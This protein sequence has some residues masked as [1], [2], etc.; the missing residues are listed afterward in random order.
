[1]KTGFF[2]LNIHNKKSMTKLFTTSIVLFFGLSLHAQMA[3]EQ[4]RDH[5][6]NRGTIAV[7]EGNNRVY[8]ANQYMVYSYS[9]QDNSLETI[10]KVDKLSDVGISAMAFDA[11]SSTLVVGYENG[12]IDLIRNG[13][14][15]NINSIVN[16]DMFGVKTIND[17]T[18]ESGRCYFSCGFG[19]VYF[20][21]INQEVI[22]TYIIGPGGVNLQVYAVDKF[23]GKIYAATDIGLMAA[24]ADN[25]FLSNFANWSLV[26]TPQPNEQVMDVGALGEH[27]FFIQNNGEADVL[28][29]TSDFTNYPELL[30]GDFRGIDISGNRIIARRDI[31][32][33]IFHPNLSLDYYVWLDTPGM[34][35]LSNEAVILESGEIWSGDEM[36]GLIHYRNIPNSFEII[37]PAGPAY[38]DNFKLQVFNGELFKLNG[39]PAS[40]WTPSYNHRGFEVLKDGE[41]TTYDS[42]SDPIWHED[43]E[44]I[45]DLMVVA[46]DPDDENHWF[47]GTWVSGILE[48]KNG[49]I[50]H[51]YSE[52]NSPLQGEGETG[53]NA[54]VAGM[55][56]DDSGNLWVS[57]G[58]ADTPVLVLDTEGEWHA[59]SPS[60][61]GAT[62]STLLSEVL[63]DQS[64]YK[65][66]V[67][68]RGNGIMV[69]NDNNTINDPDDDE[70]VAIGTQVGEG[71][72]PTM[73]IYSL[74][75]DLNG[76]IWVGTGE[77]VVVFYSPG[78]LFSGSNYDAQQILLEQDG[79]LQVLLETE[80]VNTIAVDGANRKWLGTSS[81][82]LFLMSADGTT[83]INHFTTSNSPLPSDAIQS[84][85]IDGESGEVFIGTDNGVVSYKS[86]A[87]D[88]AA[89][90]ECSKVY[91]NPVR[92]DYEGPIAITGLERNTNVKITDVAGNLIFETTSEGG[93]AIWHAQ[94]FEGNRVTT[95]VYT[96]LSTAPE[97]NSRCVAKIMVVR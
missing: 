2:S 32:V 39:K 96:A 91:P 12:N 58:Y 13:T 85:A 30:S 10:S 14:S 67:R 64:G 24:D 69:Y 65:W 63:I 20:D 46:V 53:G 73:D 35:L 50:I 36:H 49:E 88:G 61:A 81:S 34:S 56:Y 72:L 59:F 4:W 29:A 42:S 90:N 19:I 47:V 1:M 26:P 68:P 17:I 92:E 38:I 41:W 48:Y 84:L 82:G 7:A 86:T 40:N 23:D 57:N 97:G 55:A 77:G 18:I 79:N 25:S 52:E 94:N 60:A 93:Q 8:A 83:Q 62:G 28:Y 33:D 51:R 22:D 43:E 15:M 74:A 70:A 54:A 45:R 95:G 9:L 66:F 5:F 21:L 31:F 87:T 89:S 16:S 11:T 27:L 37:Q 44:N 6:P 76:E 3:L 80:I 75:E 78:S 71:N